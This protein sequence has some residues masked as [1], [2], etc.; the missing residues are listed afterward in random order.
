MCG[1]VHGVEP[2]RDPRAM[3]S[4][5]LLS[6]GD[7]FRAS[8]LT[9]VASP[10]KT[11]QH[12]IARLF[13]NPAPLIVVVCRPMASV[14]R[15]A[16][17][18]GIC[19]S[20]GTPASP[21]PPVLGSPARPGSLVPAPRGRSWPLPILVLADVSGE[22]T[23]PNGRVRCGREVGVVLRMVGPRGNHVGH[24][25]PQTTPAKGSLSGTEGATAGYGEAFDSYIALEPTST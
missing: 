23:V 8:V 17:V 21:L 25:V 24:H 11:R 18:P 1:T 15:F 9:R 13:C 4:S 20:T 19:F 5:P 12:F 7:T 16:S 3:G 2:E 14:L 6:Q 22:E 10:L